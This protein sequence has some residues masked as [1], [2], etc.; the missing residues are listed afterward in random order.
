M[1]FL[2]FYSKFIDKFAE[3]IHPLLELLKKEKLKFSW[4]DEHQLAF[5][6]LKK[7]FLEQKTIAYPNVKLPFFL[8]TD[9][10]GFAISAILSQLDENNEEKIILCVSRVLRAAEL[11]YFITE[12]E[13]LAVIWALHKLP[14]LLGSKIIIRVF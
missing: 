9:A 7:S 5:D 3:K 12:K 8:T 4:K 10:S 6:N 11:N 1:G 2:N 14:Y 13:M